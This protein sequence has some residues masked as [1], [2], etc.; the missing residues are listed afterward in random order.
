MLLLLGIRGSTQ[1]CKRKTSTVRATV[2]TWVVALV[3]LVALVVFPLLVPPLETFDWV[4]GAVE[5]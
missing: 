3:A 2:A 4:G 5:G 1:S